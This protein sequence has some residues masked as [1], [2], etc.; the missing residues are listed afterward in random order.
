MKRESSGFWRSLAGLLTASM[1]G[2]WSPAADAQTQGE[3]Q[4]EEETQP[5]K[6]AEAP[7]TEAPKRAEAS[8]DTDAEKE[9]ETA[10]SAPM[11]FAAA[12][13]IALY[14]SD[15]SG[16]WQRLCLAPCDL[17]AMPSPPFA[18]SLDGGEPVGAKNS[19]RLRSATVLEGQYRSRVS[20]R[21]AGWIILGIGIPASVTSIASGAAI[22]ASRSGESNRTIGTGTA[23]GGGVAFLTSLIIGTILATRPDEAQVHVR[24]R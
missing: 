5:Q 19:P 21:N 1:L 22:A 20:T 7:K 4:A 17:R 12:P 9:G 18:L 3:D 23:I 15:Q 6:R 13:G 2:L 11:S 8:E 10:P 16:G 14:T 24:K